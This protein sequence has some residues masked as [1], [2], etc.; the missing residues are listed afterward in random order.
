MRCRFILIGQFSFIAMTHGKYQNTVK[1]R[2][3]HCSLFTS[4][5]VKVHMLDSR[6]QQIAFFSSFFHSFF[7]NF[8]FIGPH[9]KVGLLFE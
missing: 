1:V 5:S 6:Q 2:I 4:Q 3:C 9:V 7:F 8:K